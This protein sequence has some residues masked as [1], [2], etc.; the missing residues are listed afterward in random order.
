MRRATCDVPRADV[1]RAN[2]RGAD[3]RTCEVPQVARVVPQAAGMA[4]RAEELECWQLANELR[5]EVV[6]ICSQDK[7][8]RHFRFCDGFTEAAGSVC[9]NIR[10]GFVRY[11]SGPLVQF[12]TYALASLEE[13][14]DYL[15]ECRTRK[16]IDEACHVRLR[17]LSE[18]TRATTINFMRAHQ[19]K[20]REAK[21]SSSSRRVDRT[22][23]PK[24][25]T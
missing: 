4:K 8:A 18:H 19:S 1:P 9:H 12:F 24:R 10:E 11:E 15:V 16:F 17:D 22:S 23:K 21:R 14:A 7:V 20:L 5:T 2:V 13:V 25:C 3:V 6:A